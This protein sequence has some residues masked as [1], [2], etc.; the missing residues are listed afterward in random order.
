M[1]VFCNVFLVF[2]N[3]QCPFLTVVTRSPDHTG[4]S[5]TRFQLQ[6]THNCSESLKCV[7]QVKLA[8]L[9]APRDTKV[10]K[11]RKGVTRSRTRQGCQ[12]Q[13]FGDEPNRGRNH[14]DRRHVESVSVFAIAVQT[15]LSAITIRALRALRSGGANL[16]RARV[17]RPPR[18]A[19]RS[20]IG[21]RKI[22]CAAHCTHWLN[23][24]THWGAPQNVHGADTTSAISGQHKATSML[25]R[26]NKRYQ[27][28]PYNRPGVHQRRLIRCAHRMK[29]N[30]SGSS[31]Q[32]ELSD[33]NAEG[34][35]TEGEAKPC[36]SPLVSLANPQV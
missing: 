30:A 4:F 26:A 23:W 25:L 16:E 8:C 6:K 36:C 29:K 34:R 12:R 7:T 14:T 2:I 24:N 10:E 18:D 33:I 1:Q 22:G 21:L 27:V 15:F 13:R 3:I 9:Q 5:P 32:R 11:P 31:L 28:M 20:L 19:A 35:K 17:A